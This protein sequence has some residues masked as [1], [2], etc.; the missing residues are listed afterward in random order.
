MPAFIRII[1]PRYTMII[2]MPRIKIQKKPS[3]PHIINM[4][5]SVRIIQQY[6]SNNPDYGMSTP[7]LD[8]Q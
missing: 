1:L 3:T 2:I 4:P 6:P 7:D 8:A 5:A